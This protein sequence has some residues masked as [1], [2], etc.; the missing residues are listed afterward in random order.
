MSNARFI[1]WLFELSDDLESLL[2]FSQSQIS[3][4]RELVVSRM[5]KGAQELSDLVSGGSGE[6]VRRWKD[7]CRDDLH[8][9]FL[10]SPFM[11]RAL[12]KPL[13]YAGDF[14]MMN[15]L[16]GLG[17]PADTDFGRAMNEYAISEA[18]AQAVRNRVGMLTDVLAYRAN[19]AA[20]NGR[21]IRVASI[22]CGPAREVVEFLER[23]PALGKH[24][25]MVLVDQDQAALDAA[26][27]ALGSLA[28]DTGLDVEYLRQSARNFI[29]S[30]N[31]WEYLGYCDLIYSAG[32]FDYL[33][34]DAFRRMLS[35][36]AKARKT[37]GEI[38]IGNFGPDNPSRVAMEYFT[39]WHLIHRSKEQLMAL[40]PEGFPK[41]KEI[42]VDSE[43]L[44]INLFLRI[45]F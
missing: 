10:L 21:R 8:S 1:Q 2:R 38:L 13:G 7:G 43:K 5:N 11:A 37:G 26:K 3:G 33:D 30:G 44:G 19:M 36:L 18:A 6:E 14:E 17:Q 27:V 9:Y 23:Y 42:R 45:L 24:V 20:F 15:Q 22:G 31:A 39:D 25:Q 16:Y 32:M 28:F 29:S 40:V 34:D 12:R 4:Y 35:A 41:V